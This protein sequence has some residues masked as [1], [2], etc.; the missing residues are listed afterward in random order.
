[1]P[2]TAAI[3]GLR[4]PCSSVRPAKPPGPWSAS[5]GS[6]A[7]AALRSQPAQKNRSPAPVMTPTRRSGSPSSL[8]N[9]PY[10]A[11][12]VATSTA[13]ARGLSRM[14]VSTPPDACTRTGLPPP[15]MS[16]A[17]FAQHGPGDDVPLDLAGAV[18]DPLDRG[19]A[20]QP[21]AAEDLD[22]LIGQPARHLRRI[23]LG[24]C[25]VGV[26]HCAPREPPGGTQRQELRRLEF[27]RHISQLEP[28]SLEPPHR[29]AE[30]LPTCRPSSGEVEHPLGAP[31]AGRRDGQ[32]AGPEP[33]AEQIEP[34]TLFTEQRRAGYPA[35]GKRELAVVVAAVRDRRGTAADREARRATVYQE[36]RNCRPF[37]PGRLLGAGHREH[38]DE[39]G[40]IGVADEVLG[41]V[42]YPVVA[43]PDGPG[44]HGADVRAGVRLCHRQA[45]DALAADRRKQI[46]LDLITFAC[47][48]DV[49]RPRDEP[50]Q[51]IGRPAKLPLD[52]SY[53]QFVEPASAELDREVRSVQTGRDRAV[54]DL[55]GKVLRH[56]VELLD[57]VL[58]RHEFLANEVA[59]GRDDR[60]VLVVKTEVH[61]VPF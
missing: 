17:P 7:A 35:V 39:V 33:L 32:P 20:H 14:I 13:F 51:R 46:R 31:D 25:R 53:G 5:T 40:D 9:A 42:E 19:F 2:L 12:L 44:G 57:H 50:L 10:S 28:D 6:P 48:Q 29:L 37:A 54:P 55:A 36:R 1:M 34:A 11:W 15:C 18:P 16:G 60:P 8:A 26:R 24:H 21:S 4:R 3:T 23:E 43:V 22:R 47:P 45:V 61:E 49:A 27:G 52:E 58:V 41:A 30:L 56:V 38:N 59:D